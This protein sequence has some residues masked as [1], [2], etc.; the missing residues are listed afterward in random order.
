M[1]FTNTEKGNRKM[2]HEGYMYAFQKNLANDV[3]WEC[4][5]DAE[6]NARQK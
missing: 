3:T 5:K 6:E 4:K 1:E 2:V